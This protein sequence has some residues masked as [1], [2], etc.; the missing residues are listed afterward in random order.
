MSNEE[1]IT[2]ECYYCGHKWEP[3]KAGKY[4]YKI[5]PKECPKCKDKNIV[6]GKYTKIDTYS[7]N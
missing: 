6:A 7:P 3:T 2:Y 4:Y 1:S 5:Q